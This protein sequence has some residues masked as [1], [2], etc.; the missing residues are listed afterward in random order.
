ML[1]KYNKSVTL[2]ECLKYHPFLKQKLHE[3]FSVPHGTYNL[4]IDPEMI[5][6]TLKFEKHKYRGLFSMILSR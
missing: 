2:R 4:V 6:K 3:D 5:H 1:Q